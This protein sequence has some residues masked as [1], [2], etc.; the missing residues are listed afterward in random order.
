MDKPRLYDDNIDN[1]PQLA[2]ALL[3]QL[4]D[5]GGV[6]PAD[7]TI[8]D[9]NRI[10][11]NYWYNKVRGVQGLE[12]VVYLTRNGYVGCGRQFSQWSTVEFHWSDPDPSH[13][14][15]VTE[16][17]YV[18]VSFTEATYVI[19]FP[20]LKSHNITGITVCAKNH[21]GSLI[22]NPNASQMPNSNEW[23]NM[24]VT[25]AIHTPNQGSYRNLVDL[26]GH[27]NLGGK[28]FLYLV[29]FMFAGKEWK[30]IPSEWSMEPFN[31][32]WPSSILLSQDGV[33]IDSVSFDF[34]IAEWPDDPGPAMLGADDYLH[35][36]ASADDPP[37]G[38]F[39][40]PEGDGSRLQ[41][42]GA[43]EHWNNPE[44]KLYSR[45]LGL[46]EGI[47]LVAISSLK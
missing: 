15:G 19:N 2:I 1:S 13:F 29:D 16:Q 14:T 36:A 3:K 18:P 40:D 39:Y 12:N 6:A 26:M 20:V 17:D 42:L 27:E 46:N 25:T 34:L 4:T 7:I 8:G 35:E 30:G 31:G 32:D 28:T 11:P 21:Y 37:S 45:N 24:H 22:R 10:M 33:A 9:P 5:V 41:S 38:T 43:H 44:H 23:Y 47:E